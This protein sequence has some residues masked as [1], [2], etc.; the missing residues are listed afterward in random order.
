[1][2]EMSLQWIA[3]YFDLR[4]SKVVEWNCTDYFYS[5]TLWESSFVGTEDFILQHLSGVPDLFSKTSMVLLCRI[6]C[7]LFGWV[8]CYRF[9]DAFFS[10]QT[11]V[12]MVFSAQFFMV[13]LLPSLCKKIIILLQGFAQTAFAV[14]NGSIS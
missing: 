2:R 3:I 8:Y 14:H 12:C 1:M 9:S 5:S 13:A 10:F 7:L 4:L 6:F 11:P